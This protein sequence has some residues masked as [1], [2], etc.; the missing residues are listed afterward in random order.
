M[1]L[2]DVGNAIVDGRFDAHRRDEAIA[3]P[4]SVTM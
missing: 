2:F 4:G 3:L 1:R